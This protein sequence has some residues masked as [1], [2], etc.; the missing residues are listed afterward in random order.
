MSP[1]TRALSS[2]TDRGL[3]TYIEPS[4]YPQTR[5]QKYGSR[6]AASGGCRAP[7]ALLHLVGVDAREE[8]TSAVFL[9]VFLFVSAAFPVTHVV[10]DLAMLIEVI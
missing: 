10:V 8:A 2:L 7:R 1:N 9:V 6:A 5:T 4:K 3:P